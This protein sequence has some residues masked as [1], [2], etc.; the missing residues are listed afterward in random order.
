MPSLL[1]RIRSIFRQ[2]D[3]PEQQQ[4]TADLTRPPSVPSDLMERFSSETDRVAVVRKCREMY[5]RDPRAR[6]M[7]R[8][9]ARDLTKGGFVVKVEDDDMAVEIAQALEDRLGLEQKIDDWVRLTARDGDSFLEIGV[10]DQ[11]EIAEV[12]RKPTLQM[13]RNTDKFDHFSDPERA[14]WW[15]DSIWAGQEP[16]KDA[17]WFAQWQIIHARW[18][19]DEGSRYGSPMMSAGTGHW[20]KVTEGELD[21]AVRRKT[22]AGMKYVHKFPG[23]V[24]DATV[25]EYREINKDALDNPYAAVADFFGNVDINAIQ[26]DTQ[27]GEITDVR[28]MIATWFMS[29]EV[30][31]ELLG[32][33]EDLNRDVLQEKNEE[34][35]QVIDGLR[36]WIESELL[37]PLFERQWLLQGIYPPNLNY[38]FEWKASQVVTPLELGQIA[39]AAFKLKILG[40]EDTIIW[41]LLARFLPGIDTETVLGGLRANGGQEDPE[42]IASVLSSIRGGL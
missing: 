19:H 14:F 42:R 7:I 3:P 30:P 17:T 36:T 2:A 16:P 34:Y 32:Y 37:R 15:S 35:K 21:I 5:Q 33:G 31:M 8:T 13:F 41:S 27:L 9:L 26:G 24:S 4:T 6:K 28:H 25:R 39:D 40:L 22:R 29:G 18:E 11:L 10:N 1:D 12:S 38:S 23:D 20:K